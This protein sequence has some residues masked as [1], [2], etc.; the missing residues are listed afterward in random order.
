MVEARADRARRPQP[1]APRRRK[2]APPAARPRLCRT[3]EIRED[4]SLAAARKAVGGW[5]AERLCGA[6]ERSRQGQR[7]QSARL[8]I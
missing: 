3:T 6:E 1:C 4:V 2:V 5:P 7:A 8:H